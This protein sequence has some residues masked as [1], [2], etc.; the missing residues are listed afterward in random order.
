MNIDAKITGRRLKAALKHK[1]NLFW[2]AG[3]LCLA[4]ILG[5][6]LDNVNTQKV[7]VWETGSLDS[8]YMTAKTEAA[9]KQTCREAGVEFSLLIR[10]AEDVYYDAAFATSGVYMSD[11]F[12]LTGE[13]MARYQ[14]DEIFL[15]LQGTCLEDRSPDGFF[16]EGKLL[17]LRLEEGKYL[18]LNGRSHIDRDLLC[19]L[20]RMILEGAEV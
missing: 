12:L 3:I 11:I 6:T 4:L 18:A 19:T 1:N 16:L 20:A 9:L 15:D 8:C 13:E 17:G 7:T 14:H 2:V 5:V 10:S